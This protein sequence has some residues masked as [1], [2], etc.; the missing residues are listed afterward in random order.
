MILNLGIQ[1]NQK[2]PKFFLIIFGISCLLIIC[3]Y[4]K[5]KASLRKD[6]Y[7]K[8]ILTKYGAVLMQHKLVGS[9]M[10]AEQKM[11]FSG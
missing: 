1:S 3:S 9:L 6:F 5:D 2:I 10:A 4:L 8:A 7:G 11:G